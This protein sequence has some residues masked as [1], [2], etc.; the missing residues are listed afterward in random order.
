MINPNDVNLVIF[1]LG[2]T[3]ISDVKADYEAVRRAF[4]K[5]G[6]KM[7]V[8]FKDY[9]PYLVLP[10]E[11]FYKTITPPE[12]RARWQE[13]RAA[14]HQELHASFV[15]YS[16]L[17]PA[18]AKTL[19]TL[20]NNGLSLAL[21]SRAVS[22]IVTDVSDKLEISQYFC[23]MKTEA[24]NALEKTGLARKIIKQFDAKA[25]IV[26]DSIQDLQVA[27][28]TGSLSIG[29]LYGYGGKAPEAADFTLRK[30][31]DLLTIF[32]GTRK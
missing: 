20:N 13:T 19:K 31:S 26:G 32:N 8:S 23:Y 4:I 24:D 29:V 10:S 15:E 7:P 30:F 11:E 17:Y 28:D 3:L 18:V 21:Y 12:H 14:V 27:K 6:W 9:G 2:G 25:A 22:K 5:L 16:T 1:D